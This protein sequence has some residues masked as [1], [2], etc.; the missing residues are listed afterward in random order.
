MDEGLAPQ[1]KVDEDLVDEGIADW[2]DEIKRSQLYHLH[3]HLHHLRH[4]QFFQLRPSLHH[5]QFFQLRLPLQ[6]RQRTAPLQPPR[7]QRQLVLVSYAQ[8]L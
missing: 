2:D 3:H 5:R 4:R 6:L 1:G 8:H 7:Q